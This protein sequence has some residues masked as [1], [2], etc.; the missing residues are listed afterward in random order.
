MG[1]AVYEKNKEKLKKDDWCK[2]VSNKNSCLKCLYRLY[3]TQ[4][5]WQWLSY[6]T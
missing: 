4:N 5:I 3:I 6:D 1:N 2:L